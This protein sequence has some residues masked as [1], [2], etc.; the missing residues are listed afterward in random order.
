MVWFIWG[1]LI[2]LAAG[3]CA[4]HFSQNAVNRAAKGTWAFYI[5]LVVVAIA[6]TLLLIPLLGR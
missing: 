4:H 1:I 3:A 6:T 5:L 2:G